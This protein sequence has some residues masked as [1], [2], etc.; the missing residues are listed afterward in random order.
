MKVVCL[1]N[2][3]IIVVYKQAR[4][5]ARIQRR[6]YGILSADRKF[7]FIVI[8]ISLAKKKHQQKKK[9]KKNENNHKQTLSELN[10]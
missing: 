8:T 3:I 6:K 9:K 7:I 10:I 1:I 4:A 5:Y 2:N